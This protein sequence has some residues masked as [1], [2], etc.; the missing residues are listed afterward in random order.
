M[1]KS[2]DSAD[3]EG[4]VFLPGVELKHLVDLLDVEGRSGWN[5]SLLLVI[6]QVF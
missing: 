2:G 6:V 4:K 1:N 3:K 5:I